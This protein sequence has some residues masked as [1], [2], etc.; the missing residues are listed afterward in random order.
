[1]RVHFFSIRLFVLFALLIPGASRA[2]D[3]GFTTLDVKGEQV[4]IYPEFR[5]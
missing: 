5:S 2:A 4:T 3:Q 1:M